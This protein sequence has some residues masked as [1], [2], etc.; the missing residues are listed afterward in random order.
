MERPSHHFVYAEIDELCVLLLLLRVDV[1]HGWIRYLIRELI[2][3]SLVFAS[4]DRHDHL[5]KGECL[6]VTRLTCDDVQTSDRCEFDTIPRQ[7]VF[8]C[9]IG[10][11]DIEHVL[12]NIG[13]HPVIVLQE[14]L[15]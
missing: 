11:S 10:L 2:S 9:V 8:R 1:E 6:T 15:F 12:L 13:I 4:Q 3:Q 7:C 5:S 14:A